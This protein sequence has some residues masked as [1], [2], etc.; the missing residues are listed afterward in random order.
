VHGD[1]PRRVREPDFPRAARLLAAA[2]DAAMVVVTAS[3]F[4]T[5]AI[6]VVDVVMRYAFNAPLAFAYDLIAQYLLVAA[7]FLALSYTLRVDGHMNVDML[8]VAIASPR[9]RAGLRAVGDALS[10]AFFLALLYAGFASAY[11]AW[12]R[13]ER[14]TGALP[15]PIWISQAFVPLGAALLVLRLAYRLAVDVRVLSRRGREAALEPARR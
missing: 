12:D 6:T 1:E 2:E 15:L 14:L 4:A 11:E 3:L 5:M 9:A 7:F 13:A 10:L 8:L